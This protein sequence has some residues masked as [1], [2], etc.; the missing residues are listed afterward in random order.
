M[1]RM[2]NLKDDYFRWLYDSIGKQRKSYKK[3]C[4][5]LHAKPFRWSV[6]NDDNRCK[7]GLDLRT[8]YI[9][10]KNLDETHLEVAYFLKGDCTTFEVL[11][12][13]AQRIDFLMYDLNP[14]TNHKSRWF[15]EMVENLNLK[16]FD[17][18]ISK[19]GRFDPV[20]EAEIDDVLE[21]LMD[22]TYDFYGRASL[23]P[24]KKRP[25][26]DLAQVEIW[27]QLMWYLDENYG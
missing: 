2:T 4:R 5:V 18:L 24:M 23:F 7:D 16:K 19:D 12:G 8:E 11:V 22:R 3:L 6:P 10:E 20:S 27:Y 25:P 15:M 9:E 21:V 14:K 17:D 13:L 1:R 26:K